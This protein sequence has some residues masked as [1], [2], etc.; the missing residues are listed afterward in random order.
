MSDWQKGD[1]SCTNLVRAVRRFEQELP[2]WWWTIG[3]CSVS[4]HAS[5]GPDVK[6][7][8]AHLLSDRRFDSGFHADFLQPAYPAD[9]LED[10]KR[11]AIKAKGEAA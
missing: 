10:V 4:A 3:V 7:P 5:C 6:G 1:R 8:D 11:Q 9:A 2:G